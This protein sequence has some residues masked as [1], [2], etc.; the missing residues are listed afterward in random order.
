MRRSREPWLVLVASLACSWD[1]WMWATES[2]F[3]PGQVFV[4][5]LLSLPFLV[6]AAALEGGA[7]SRRLAAALLPAAVLLGL[8]FVLLR[9]A[10][11]AALVVI[12]LYDALALVIVGAASLST[13]PRSLTR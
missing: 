1:G 13:R 8:L 10:G 4:V 2:G 9:S 11:L 6:G 12:P 7:E 3:H 5:S